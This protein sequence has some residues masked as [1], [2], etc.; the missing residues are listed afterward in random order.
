MPA[1]VK[2][3]SMLVWFTTEK[4]K[5]YCEAFRDQRH[6]KLLKNVQKEKFFKTNDK[7]K[8]FMLLTIFLYLSFLKSEVE[9][10]SVEEHVA[11]LNIAGCCFV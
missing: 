3:Q 8:S 11:F 6:S 9:N 2:L 7:D 10:V 4:K 5:I 1:G